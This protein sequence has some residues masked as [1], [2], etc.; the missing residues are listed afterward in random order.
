[1]DE[2]S[3]Y[4]YELSAAQIAAQYTS[5]ITNSTFNA[6]ACNSTTGTRVCD[7]S[8]GGAARCECALGFGGA[9]C[10]SVSFTYN[11]NVSNIVL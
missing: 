10:S 4:T 5:A 9:D 3:I 6:V 8:T 2:L 11:A 1:M 7:A